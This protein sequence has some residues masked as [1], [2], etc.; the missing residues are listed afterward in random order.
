[1]ATS[2]QIAKDIDRVVGCYDV[3]PGG[4]NLGSDEQIRTFLQTIIHSFYIFV[5]FLA[6]KHNLEGSFFFF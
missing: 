6:L 2:G 1:M 4:E 5:Y 3:T